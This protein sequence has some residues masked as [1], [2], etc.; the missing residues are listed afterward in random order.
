MNRSEDNFVPEKCSLAGS[1]PPLNAKI[2]PCEKSRLDVVGAPRPGSNATLH[3]PVIGLQ[4][5]R[6]L[7][8]DNVLAQFLQNRRQTRR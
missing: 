6:F 4:L 7:F 8:W 1:N 3:G 5:N 2:I